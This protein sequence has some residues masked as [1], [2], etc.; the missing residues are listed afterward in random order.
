MY[1]EIE[2]FAVIRIFLCLV[3]SWI[4]SDYLMRHDK[5][6]LQNRSISI[7]TCGAI[8]DIIL[9]FYSLCQKLN[10]AVKEIAAKR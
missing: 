9:M 2:R 8:V 7:H 5:K 1:V 4:G 6:N 3:S 10:W